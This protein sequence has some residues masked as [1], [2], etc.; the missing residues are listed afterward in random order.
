MDDIALAEAF[1]YAIR[2]CTENAEIYLAD[3]LA[4]CPPLR[5]CQADAGHFDCTRIGTHHAQAWLASHD[6]RRT[7]DFRQVPTGLIALAGWDSI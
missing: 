3:F 7:Q 6:G 1:D 5:G 4:H 2:D